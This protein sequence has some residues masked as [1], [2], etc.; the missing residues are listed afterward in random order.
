MNGEYYTEDRLAQLDWLGR[1]ALDLADPVC[2]NAFP[3]IS[4]MEA[5]GEIVAFWEAHTDS[6]P[7]WYNDHDRG[8]L[9]KWVAELVFE[10]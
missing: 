9:I 6:L 3:G 10:R 2:P 4:P 7:E 1:L 5:A 8:L